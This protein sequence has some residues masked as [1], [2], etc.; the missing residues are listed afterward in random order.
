MISLMLLYKP[1]SLFPSNHASD[2]WGEEEHVGC[3][4]CAKTIIQ[5]ARTEFITHLSA[6]CYLGHLLFSPFFCCQNL[7]GK[8]LKIIHLIFLDTQLIPGKENLFITWVR[9]S[10]LLLGGL[11]PDA[12]QQPPSASCKKVTPFLNACISDSLSISTAAG[13]ESSWIS[14]R[15][16]RCLNLGCEE[17]DRNHSKGL[18]FNL[19]VTPRLKLGGFYHQRI[20]LIASSFNIKVTI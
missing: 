1:W 9:M 13:M 18:S 20:S 19:S 7:N 12:F 10:V 16:A 17:P 6:G 8:C 4:D 2:L 14:P 11:Y 15:Q 5:S 3:M